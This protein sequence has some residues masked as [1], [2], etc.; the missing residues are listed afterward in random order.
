[1]R[2][3]ES[4]MYSYYVVVVPTYFH[5]AKVAVNTVQQVKLFGVVDVLKMHCVSIR[6]IH[7]HCPEWQLRDENSDQQTAVLPIAKCDASEN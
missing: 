3:N 4:L 5:G 7:H 1:M 6:V 2:L